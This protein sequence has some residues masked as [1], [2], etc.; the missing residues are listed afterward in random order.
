VAKLYALILLLYCFSAVAEDTTENLVDNDNWTV[1]GDVYTCTDCQWNGAGQK[2]DQN[3]DII[4]VYSDEQGTVSQTFDLTPY[5]DIG[6]I[7]YG[8]SSFGCNNIPGGGSLTCNQTNQPEYYDKITVELNYG[9]QVYTDIVTLDFNNFYVDYSFSAET[10]FDADSATLSFSSIDPAA[11]SNWYMAGATHSAFFNV[12]YNVIDLITTTPSLINPEPDFVVDVPQVSVDIPIQPIEVAPS[13]PEVVTVIEVPVDSVGS[14]VPNVTMT[15][16]TP[17]IVEIA[18]IQDLD[19]ASP[20]VDPMDSPEPEI[21]VEMKTETVEPEVQTDLSEP[22][23][24]SET[25]E[26][27]PESTQQAE[28]QDQEEKPEPE[29]ASE[30]EAEPQ[31]EVAKEQK[32][33]QQDKQESSSESKN[34]TTSENTLVVRI[35]AM[36][37]DQVA[38][39]FESVYN[40]QAQAV[41]IAVMTMTAQ[42]YENLPRLEDVEFYEDKG[43]KDKRGFKDRL[44]GSI[45]RDEKLWSEMVDVQYE[46]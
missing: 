27:E 3:A 8:M 33:D 21:V 34:N 26:L 30:P 19:M 9:G 7:D 12:T 25:K 23:Q 28:A 46:Y 44:W 32:P 16:T 1:E 2:M 38:A 37:M 14:A 11:Y 36:D 17:V 29:S 31:M 15:N 39:N 41:A 42:G 22:E 35:N 6:Q 43:L 20:S 5:N 45:Y 18:E 4:W 10:T 40:A 24:Q 13:Q